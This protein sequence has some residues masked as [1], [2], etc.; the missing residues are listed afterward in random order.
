MVTRAHGGGGGDLRIHGR[1]GAADGREGVTAYAGIGIEARAQ[2]VVSAGGSVVY[3]DGFA[4][5]G[6]AVLEVGELAGGES[7]ERR[8]GGGRAAAHAGVTG[9][10]FRS[11]RRWT[12]FA[13]GPQR[14]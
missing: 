14:G 3:V 5:G 13:L 2:A 10:H 12:G 11:W 8:S 9:G 6:L 4:E 7:A 1:A